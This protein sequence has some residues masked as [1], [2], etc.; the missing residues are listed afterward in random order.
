MCYL[1]ILVQWN[2]SPTT[3]LL[4]SML[5]SFWCHV[6]AYGPKTGPAFLRFLLLDYFGVRGGLL[7]SLVFVLH[8]LCSDRLFYFVA[9]TSCYVD[10]FGVGGW[11]GIINVLGLRPSRPS[12][13][14]ICL[15]C[16]VAHTSCYVGYVFSASLH[17]L[18]VTLD[19]S[20]LLRCTHFMLCWVRLVFF[21]AHTSCYVGYVLS[22]SLH[23]LHV[24]LGMSSLFLL[25]ALHE[26]H[27]NYVGYVLSFSLRTLH[28]TLGT[29]CLFRCTHFMLRWIRLLC[30][31]AHTS[32]YV[33]YV[34][35]SSLQTLHVTLDMSS[36][37][38]CTIDTCGK[39][40]K[41]MLPSSLSSQSPMI[42]T[43]AKAWQWRYVYRNGNVCNITA[44]TV[45][46]L[47]SRKEN[48][49]RCGLITHTHTHPN[50]M[51]VK[52]WRFC[53]AI[54]LG[55]MKNVCF[56]AVV[57]KKSMLHTSKICN[58]FWGSRTCIFKL[59]LQ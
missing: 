9:H 31:V 41:I 29:S 28:V 2:P 46:K 18:H 45:S 24:T 35:S 17:T 52:M 6:F 56:T 43:Y 14:W 25:H 33:G 38:H 4:G 50:M 40:C 48:F 22:T 53:T 42:M 51:I 32:C 12:L 11:G 55:S 36:L 49:W 47:A 23:T 13:R 54:P 39:A 37:L 10:Y 57:A 1:F 30:F 27:V 34:F 44:K 15:L 7:T 20:C 5:W 16:V 19:M 3:I 58:V 21:V 26:L 8:D 59:P